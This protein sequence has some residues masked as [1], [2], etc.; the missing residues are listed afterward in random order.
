MDDI[1]A[2]S[3][4]EFAFQTNGQC[5]SSQLKEKELILLNALKF[6]LNAPTTISFLHHYIK[7]KE[8]KN[9]K[10]LMIATYLCEMALCDYSTALL[11]PSIVASAALYLA[12]RNTESNTPSWV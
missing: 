4:Y 12:L 1:R 9:E 3:I 6:E 11:T 5:K 10:V 7:G 8:I 2:P